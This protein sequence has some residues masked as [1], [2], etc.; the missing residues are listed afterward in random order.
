[1]YMIRGAKVGGL[2]GLNPP[3]FWVPK[4]GGGLNPLLILRI[5]KKIEHIYYSKK[6]TLYNVKIL[7]CK[8]G[9]A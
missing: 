9:L 8:L 7:K 1:M 6:W 3:K 4:L 5:L 2:R